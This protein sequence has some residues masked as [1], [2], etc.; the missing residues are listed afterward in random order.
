MVITQHRSKR[1]PTGGRYKKLYRSK[2]KAEI[3]KA[4]MH[5]KLDKSKTKII[6]TKGGNQKTK[7]LSC[8]VVNVYDPKSKKCT[9]SKIKTILENKANRHYVR[10]SILTKGTIVETELGK[11]KI[12]S[13]PGQEGAMNAV[14]V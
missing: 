4:P 2:R 9:K 14:L 13:R 5:T 1:K 11:A 8:D 3:G 10:R 12:T 6:R 7:L